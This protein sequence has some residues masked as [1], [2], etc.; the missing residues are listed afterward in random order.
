[1]SGI[2]PAGFTS[3]ATAV[4]EEVAL[5]ASGVAEAEEVVERN[6][7]EGGVRLVEDEQADKPSST[8]PMLATAVR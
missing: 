2:S 6:G 7:L 1:M 4:V 3:G 5:D 8:R